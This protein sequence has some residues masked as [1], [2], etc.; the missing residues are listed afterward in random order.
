[1]TKRRWSDLSE[2]TRKRIVIIGLIEGVLKLFALID[3]RRRPAEQVRGPKWLWATSLSVVSSGG[4]L[5]VCYFLFGR[6]AAVRQPAWPF[7]ESP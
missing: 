3:L 2:G 1:M 4:V 5:P 6:R 7:P